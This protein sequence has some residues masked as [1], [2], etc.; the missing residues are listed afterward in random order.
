MD[1]S[2]IS[3]FDRRDGAVIVSRALEG[4]QAIVFIDNVAEK[5]RLTRHLPVP[6]PAG[7]RQARPERTWTCEARPQSANQRWRPSTPDGASTRIE[8]SRLSDRGVA[9]PPEARE[10]RKSLD[11]SCFSIIIRDQTNPNCPKHPCRSHERVN[12]RAAVSRRRVSATLAFE[13]LARN[14]KYSTH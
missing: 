8:G 4:P 14:A 5:E 6:R 1:S 7:R 10:T 12:N 3:Q 11:R 2:R 13:D 9:R